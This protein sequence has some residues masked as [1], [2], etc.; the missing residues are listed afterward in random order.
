MYIFSKYK[1]MGFQN[2][3]ILTRFSFWLHINSLFLIDFSAIY[4]KNSIY[5]ILKEKE[6][7]CK[8]WFKKP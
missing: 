2:W 4:Y 6:H 3:K 8:Q 1:V 5:D 7:S